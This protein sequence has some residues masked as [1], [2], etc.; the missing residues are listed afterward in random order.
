[1]RQHGRDVRQGKLKE[2][3][4]LHSLGC[5]TRMPIHQAHNR[6][7]IK[8]VLKWKLVGGVRVIKARITM[9]GFNL[10]YICPKV[11]KNPPAEN[12][13]IV[14]QIKDSIAR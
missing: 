12:P 8:W 6:V 7:D 4:T 2:L 1:M 11:A 9:R 3:Q 14:R 13:T 10:D 5:F